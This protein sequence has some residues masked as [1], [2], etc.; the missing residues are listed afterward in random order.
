[1]FTIDEELIKFKNISLAEYINKKHQSADLIE[2]EAEKNAIKS[3]LKSVNDEALQFFLEKKDP[4]LNLLQIHQNC[5]EAIEKFNNDEELQFEEEE[6]N[7]IYSKEL[8][9]KLELFVEDTTIFLTEERY[10]VDSETFNNDEVLCILT[11]DLLF[12]GERV[13]DGRFKMR[14]SISID[15]IKMKTD[16]TNLKIILD[17]SHCVLTGKEED[18]ESFFESFQEISY[19]Y[20]GRTEET[21]EVDYGLILY[22]I[23]TRRYDELTKYGKSLKK[24][25]VDDDELYRLVGDHL[26]NGDAFSAII[27]F[28]KTPG[29]FCK[30]FF[31]QRLK[32][33]LVQ[34]NRIQLLAPYIEDLFKFVEEYSLQL[35]EYFQ[36]LSFDRSD[37]VLILEECYRS[38]IHHVEPRIQSFTRL[39]TDKTKNKEILELVQSKLRI[40]SENGTGRILLDFRYL[41]AEISLSRPVKKSDLEKSKEKIKSIIQGY[42]SEI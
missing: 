30:I 10:F 33:S 25:L 2:I 18:V 40:E 37:L 8:E 7:K 23:Q 11:N 1:M 16:K 41:I 14:R 29:N 31:T 20:H 32:K 22:Y 17:G 38:V 6:V 27:P 12:I 34:V 35:V 19:K 13:G 42:L 21:V 9:K 5:Y 36:R 39:N 26:D 24:G 3:I 15:C 28:L 4:L